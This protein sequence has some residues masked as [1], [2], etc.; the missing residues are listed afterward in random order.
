MKRQ[1]KQPKNLLPLP[2]IP[3]HQPPRRARRVDR[4]A[5]VRDV[6]ALRGRLRPHVRVRVQVG[7]DEADRDVFSFRRRSRLLARPVEVLLDGRGRAAAAGA[8]VDEDVGREGGEVEA[9]EVGD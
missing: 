4:A 6:G 3:L 1:I 5:H 8:E 9:E 7:Q 2:T